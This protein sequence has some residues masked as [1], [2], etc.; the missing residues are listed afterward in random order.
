M[1]TSFLCPLFI[2]VSLKT[3]M[4]TNWDILAFRQCADKY[5][6]FVVYMLLF[7]GQM[8]HVPTSDPSFYFNINYIAI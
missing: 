6:F 3:A 7:T 1:K 5:F 8:H 2:F 4:S